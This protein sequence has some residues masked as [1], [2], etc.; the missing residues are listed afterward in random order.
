MSKSYGSTWKNKS[1]YTHYQNNKA[2]YIEKARLSAERNYRYIEE[3]KKKSKCK[4]CGNSDYRVLDFDHLPEF[5]KVNDISTLAHHGCS[6]SKIEEEIKKCDVICSNCH[7]IRTWKR[8][9]A[10]I[11]QRIEQPASNGKIE[12]P[13][14]SE[15]A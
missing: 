9:Q 8:K 11:A 15:S 10:L 4:D 14:P 5:K 3:V 7:R 2:Y 6:I 12:G 13:I 1:G